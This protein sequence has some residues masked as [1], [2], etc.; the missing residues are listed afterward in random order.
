MVLSQFDQVRQRSLFY[1][2]AGTHACIN[3]Y[4]T[5]TLIILHYNISF[6]LT[7]PNHNISTWFE[8]NH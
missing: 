8:V 7:H 5:Q 3:E 6:L 2:Q 4:C 1:M